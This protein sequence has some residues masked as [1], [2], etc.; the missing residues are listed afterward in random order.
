MSYLHGPICRKISKTNHFYEFELGSYAV[1]CHWL[2]F[3]SYLFIHYSDVIMS[4]VASQISGVVIVCSTVCWGADQRNTPKP[5]VTGLVRGIH[6]WPTDSPHKGPET[7]KPFPFDDVIMDRARL[8]TGGW[9]ES[10]LLTDCKC[11]LFHS[12][13]EPKPRPM[14]ILFITTTALQYIVNNEHWAK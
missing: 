8:H 1:R 13:P 10:W 14:P 6:R 11:F 12:N 3:S 9:T 4:T 5:R 7:W 2:A